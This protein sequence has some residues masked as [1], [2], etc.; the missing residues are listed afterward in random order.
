ML[1]VAIGK[2]ENEQINPL[3]NKVA[4]TAHVTQENLDDIVWNISSEKRTLSDIVDRMH[5]FI[6]GIF[7]EQPINLNFNVDEELKSLIIKPER[8]YDL[9]LIFKE[10]VNNAAKYAM[11][12]SITVELGLEG[13]KVKFYY[14]DDG[15]GFEPEK[16]TAGNGLSNIQTRAKNLRGT[17]VFNSVPG[18]GTNFLLKF[19]VK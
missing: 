14:N 7:E 12:N 8:R 1:K 3:L 16:E 2:S 9:Y 5:E 19:P 15:I 10:L 11:A 4:Y 6:Y 18:T 17:L 13:D